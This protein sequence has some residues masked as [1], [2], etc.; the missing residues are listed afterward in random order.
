VVLSEQEIAAM[1]SNP[2]NAFLWQSLAIFLLVGA[3]AG[4]LLGLLLI[5]KPQWVSTFNRAANR[6][7]S[8]R[9]LNQVL[10]RS[11][12]VEHWFYRHHRPAGMIVMLGAVYMFVYFGLLFDQAAAIPRLGSQVPAQLLEGLLDAL[13]LG[14]LVGAV[15]AF[16]G[17][18]FLW[19][20]PGALR[21]IEA[22]ANRWVSSRRATKP[23]DVPRD[24]VDRFVMS[25]A[26]R[27][28]WLLLLGSLYL[29]FVMTGWLM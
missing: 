10:D 16:M 27:M 28:G 13:V 25:H 24:Q 21:N 1:P 18:V 14:A 12:S 26:R 4:I 5:L 15:A 22:R 8:M 6:W 19:L 20:R 2:M 7:I 11:V 9:R 29:F 17:G 23:L 3:L